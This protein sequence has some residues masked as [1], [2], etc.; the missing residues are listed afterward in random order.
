V[1][2]YGNNMTP[3][4]GDRYPSVCYGVVIGV[5]IQDERGLADLVHPRLKTRLTPKKTAVTHLVV[6]L[7]DRKDRVE[8]P[9]KL[10]AVRDAAYLGT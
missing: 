7:T 3:G 10:D 2:I 9:P 6:P 1:S 4:G 8:G 5:L